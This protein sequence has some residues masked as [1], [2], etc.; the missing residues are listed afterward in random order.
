MAGLQQL[1][2]YV[3]AVGR[4]EVGDLEGIS[5]VFDL[6]V[7]PRYALVRKADVAVG[8]AADRAQ[9]TVRDEEGATGVL[10]LSDDQLEINLSKRRCP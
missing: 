7:V 8:S 5:D 3:G 9:P 2:I 1:A 6:A 10:A 4:L